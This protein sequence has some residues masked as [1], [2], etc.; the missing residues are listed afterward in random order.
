MVRRGRGAITKALIDALGVDADTL[1]GAHL[2]DIKQAT[3]EVFFPV[4]AGTEMTPAV[5]HPCAIIDHAADE[6][7]IHVFIPH[8][9]NSMVSLELIFAPMTTVAAMKASVYT[10]YGAVGEAPA[11]HSEQRIDGSIGDVTTNTIQAHDISDL[12]DSAPVAVGD[13]VGV[14]I[15]YSA[16]APA[17]NIRVY[18]VRMRYT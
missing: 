13:Y 11:E 4:T 18:G 16:V 12:V 5:N 9:Y 14:Y 2:A 15:L 7:G 1:D 10:A 17:T 3:K 8:D 6:C